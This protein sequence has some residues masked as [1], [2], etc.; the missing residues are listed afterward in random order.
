MFLTHTWQIISQNQF[1]NKQLKKF[2]LKNSIR[3]S[4]YS[5]DH[6]FQDKS[7]NK[8]QVY[9]NLTPEAQQNSLKILKTTSWNYS[10][11][12][13]NNKKHKK[14]TLFSSNMHTKMKLREEKRDNHRYKATKTRL[15]NIEPYNKERKEHTKHAWTNSR[16]QGSGSRSTQA[17]YCWNST[18]RKNENKFI[19]LKVNY[20]LISWKLLF[21]FINYWSE[22]RKRQELLR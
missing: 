14:K 21:I 22:F 18:T 9:Y 19:L 11:E 1:T 4:L 7:A 10:Q 6:L 2:H 17:V 12:I 8:H 16:L 20:S 3:N 5:K 15:P 13:Q